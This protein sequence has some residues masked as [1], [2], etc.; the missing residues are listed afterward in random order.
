MNETLSRLY[1][2]LYDRCWCVRE[3]GIL[4][5]VVLSGES[6]KKERNLF[7]YMECCIEYSFLRITYPF[8]NGSHLKPMR[9]SPFPILLTHVPP[10]HREEELAK[11]PILRIP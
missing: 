7:C 1:Y 8:D 2:R 3:R 9:T 10:N 5:G 4:V 6:K 11:Q